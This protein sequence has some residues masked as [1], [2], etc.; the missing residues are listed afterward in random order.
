MTIRA[1]S[2]HEH[3]QRPGNAPAHRSPARRRA[4][5]RRLGTLGEAVAL[6]AAPVAC[7]FVLRLRAMSPQVIPDPALTSVFLWDPRDLVVRYA[8][9][10]LSP[11][12]RAYIGPRAAYLRWGTRA[13]FLVPG[14]LAYLALGTLPGFFGFRYALA[15]VATV[16]SYLLAKRTWGAWAGAL[17][18]VAVMACPVVVS[19]WGTDFPDSAALSY[20]LGGTACLLMPSRSVASRRAWKVV[21]A[22]LLAASVWALATVAV[23]LAVLLVVWALAELATGAGR[24]LVEEVG[25]LAGG[26]A[27]TTLALSVGSWALLGRFDF[28]LPTLRALLFLDTPAQELLWHST[29]PAWAPYDVYLLV[30]PA[31][32]VAW[33]LT[34]LLRRRRVERLTVLVG[35]VATGQLALACYLQFLG[36]VQILEDHY[37]S[38]TIWA[39]S[40]LTLVAVAAEIARPFSHRPLWRWAPAAAVVIVTLAVEAL[41]TPPEM[42]WGPFGYLLVGFVA[43][44]TLAGYAASRPGARVVALAAVLAGLLVLTVTPS[45]TLPVLQGT[46]PDPYPSYAGTLGGPAGRLVDVYLLEHQVREWVPNATYL[47]EQLVTCRS[48]TRSLLQLYLIG[49]FHAGINLVPGTCPRVGPG[50][51]REIADRKAAQL[52]VISTRPIHLDELL[53]RLAPLGPRVAKRGHLEEGKVGCWLWLIDFPRYLGSR[54]I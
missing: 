13:G 19:A 27:A 35:A 16:P 45:P 36:S 2:A 7:L 20:L 49:M 53:G 37:L 54:A 43:I 22:S 15:L 3:G 34:V 10:V 1:V 11:A 33:A 25:L 23:L 31:V 17:A 8:P 39:A 21:A 9:Q 30:L 24:R 18:V 28:E 14:R 46:V 32:V 40:L 5:Q 50:V 47:G 52:L 38:S 44:A 41:P 6:L 12:L 4:R 29:N 26:A 48:S 42:R 51:R